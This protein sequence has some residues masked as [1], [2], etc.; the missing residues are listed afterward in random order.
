VDVL[1]D[2]ELWSWW[3]NGLL[4][5]VFDGE[6][7]HDNHDQTN[8]LFTDVSTKG[9]W[10]RYNRVVGG[11]RL[12]QER[13]YEECT[14][15][16]FLLELYD[17]T[18]V[19]GH[20]YN[21]DPEAGLFT[22]R[23]ETT[24]NPQREEWL[25]ILDS[26]ET[27]T[28]KTEDL[29]ANGWYD[30]HTMKIEFAIPV[31]NAEFGV[32][33]IVFVNFYKSRGGHI[34]KKVIPRSQ[35]ASW[36]YRWWFII[37]DCV[38]LLCVL[39]IMFK[40]ITDIILK[41]RSGDWKESVHLWA[42]I[43]WLTVAGAFAIIIM[44]FSGLDM[45]N[46][47]NDHLI[48]LGTIDPETDRERWEDVAKVYT[49]AL[50]DNVKYVRSQR[51]MMA[52]YPLIIMARLVK[53]FS[54]QPRLALVTKT[55]SSSVV[56]LFHF[57]LVFASVFSAFL[58]CGVVLFGKDVRSF[59]TVPR[60]LITCFRIMFGDV[61]WESLRVVGRNLAGTWL[62][63]FIVSISL[64]MVNMILAII[65]DHYEEVKSSTGYKETLIE[66]TVQVVGRWWRIRTGKEVSLYDI[67]AALV[68]N[69]GPA[70]TDP[71]AMKRMVSGV[72]GSLPFKSED[73][74][75]ETAESESAE[76]SISNSTDCEDVNSSSSSVDKRQSVQLS[77]TRSMGRTSII[78]AT[79]L[80]DIARV[81]EDQALE[82]IQGA[83]EDFHEANKDDADWDELVFLVERS[84]GRARK[85]AK[86][87]REA[88]A[89]KGV[90]ML[91]EL[92]WF[93]NQVT[94][95]L[96]AVSA[97]IDDGKREVDRLNALKKHFQHLLLQLPPSVVFPITE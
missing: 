54:A 29:E 12:R 3:K 66:E 86:L 76:K 91:E 48:L 83:I 53:A 14:S 7:W 60:A 78:F 28:Q 87:A 74:E 85:C 18:C 61:E 21:I 52:A 95:H 56:D 36:H 25:W 70:I 19:G 46:H 81:S 51:L 24:I 94:L 39:Y 67:L 4:P 43:D 50:E 55:L 20:D 93:S 57:V 88:A 22:Q 80:Q 27:V 92:Q 69:S 49:Q 41:Y 47:M 84:D 82:I 10:L 32:H 11:I 68:E 63:L 31:Y 59:T 6:G 16:D 77:H 58:V 40:S 73:D 8:P 35:H 42:A 38:W 72:M 33:T 9:F 23:A 34:F 64:I 5:L 97:E 37:I 26:L 13:S 96:E 89:A 2:E 75:T 90:G 62:V 30:R 44:F 65:V 15:T 79:D 1:Q 17:G 71:S 45:R